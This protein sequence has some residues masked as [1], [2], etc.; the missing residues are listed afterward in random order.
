VVPK[1][2]VQQV[3]RLHSTGV[4]KPADKQSCGFVSSCAAV[5]EEQSR[6]R[7]SMGICVFII[8]CYCASQGNREIGAAYVIISIIKVI[9]PFIPTAN[10]PMQRHPAHIFLKTH[11]TEFA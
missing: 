6:W 5:V 7:E 2:V 11:R 1:W 4:H 3:S 10:Q 9:H 8:M